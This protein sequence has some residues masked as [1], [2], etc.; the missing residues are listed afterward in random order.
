[1][2]IVDNY[3]DYLHESENIN[4]LDLVGDV[5][6]G[7]KSGA[8]WSLLAI[9]AGIAAWKLAN[10]AFSKAARKCGGLKKASPG[11]KICVARERNKALLNKI[12][13]AKNIL[14]KCPQAKNPELCKQT[15]SLEIE[16][17]QNRIAMNQ[18]KIQGL[19]V[20]EQL[21]NESENLQEVIP[22]LVS[23]AV[24][25]AAQTV[26]DKAIFVINRSAQGLFKES[27]RKCGTFKQGA[28]I[29]LCMS[30]IKLRVLQ[31]KLTKIS[32]LK[33]QCK[34]DKKPDMC[35]AKVQKHIDK[36]NRDIQIERD[37]ITAYG[38]QVELEKRE[39]ALKQQMKAGK[40]LSKGTGI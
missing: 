24:V 6:S 36:I 15:F 14:S 31:N 28:E 27:V 4:E 17:A 11:Y 30:K 29:D 1:M 34:G 20:G 39:A 26:V 19:L 18:N 25:M 40:R 5:V 37:N 33:T 35:V 21:T 16:K 23:M 3:L 10:V 32:A 38:N 8:R 9:P 12:N 2:S 13:V 7:V 22:A